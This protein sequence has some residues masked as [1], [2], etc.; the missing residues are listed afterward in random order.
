MDRIIWEVKTIDAEYRMGNRRLQMSCYPDN[1]V[2]V[3]ETENDLQCLLHR[4]EVT[5]KK[6]KM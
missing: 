4:I 1:A 5:V 2:L 3:V 6:Y